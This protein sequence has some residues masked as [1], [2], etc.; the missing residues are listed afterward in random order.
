MSGSFQ[1]FVF[2]PSVLTG[3]SSVNGQSSLYLESSFYQGLPSLSPCTRILNASQSIGCQA[4]AASGVL[5]AITSTEDVAAFI[6]SA[7][8]ALANYVLVM[9]PSLLQRHD[10]LEF[11]SALAATGRMAGVIVSQDTI[12][13]PNSQPAAFSPDSTTPNY[14]YGLY[15][16]STSAP[17]IWNPNGNSL[18]YQNY[19]YPIFGGYPFDTSSQTTLA[20][21]REAVL[22]NKAKGYNQYPLY[23][24][25]FDAFMWAAVDSRTCLRRSWCDP[26]GGLSVWSTLS[27]NLASND[28][29]PIIVVASKIDGDAFFHDLA[30]GVE[31]TLSGMITE[32]AVIDALRRST[33]S[34]TTLPKH[35]VFTFFNAENF[36]LAGS[37][38]FVQDISSTFSCT[39][40]PPSGTTGGTT[41]CYT[42]DGIQAAC[43]N[44]C[45]AHSQFTRINFNNIES[46]IELGQVSSAA[47]TTG[48][49]T[50][51]NFYLHSDDENADNL[52]LKTRWSSTFSQPGYNGGALPVTI[53]NA[54]VAGS[55]SK[56]LPPSSA[57]AFLQKK[58]I[59]AMVISDFQSQFSN[60]FYNSEYDT[61][62]RLSNINITS[63][64]AIANVTAKS[65]WGLASNDGV[66][67]PSSVVVNCSFVAEL[68]SCL[69]GNFSCPLIH[70]LIGATGVA[71]VSNYPSVFAYDNPSA[72]TRF[73]KSLVAT[74]TGTPGVNCS[75]DADCTQPTGMCVSSTC[76]SSQTFYHYAFGT[77]IKFNADASVWEVTDSTKGTWVESRWYS[78]RSR[79][80]LVSA[81]SIQIVQVVVGVLLTLITLGIALYL[82]R[83][84]LSKL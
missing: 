33:T 10:N 55:V 62:T 48:N 72:Y 80:L 58:R 54:V 84:L 24:A 23:S 28:G 5:Y 15:A 17:V 27:T 57:M 22:S 40:S 47:S 71:H 64:C 79:L 12:L 81:P 66:A 25:E 21:L 18:I 73:L 53:Q 45:F 69:A 3:P 2:T 36:G 51:L 42:P 1:Y 49:G 8:S 52:A 20:T 44:P 59:P 70:G 4:G 31:S 35:I 82:E 13:F 75:S 37:Q 50:S 38:R 46:V 29:K 11:L 77:G 60:P 26:I 41:G 30:W 67:L 6:D 63:L 9:P 56:R 68:V 34:L 65:L 43:W 7:P 76:I 16:N 14:Q 74:I 83:T 39:T 32:L 61:N 78:T 19:P